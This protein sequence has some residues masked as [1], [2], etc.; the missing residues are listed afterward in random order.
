VF[1]LSS[2]FEKAVGV[3]LAPMQTVSQQLN[4]R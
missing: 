2:P 1:A 4:A 3:S